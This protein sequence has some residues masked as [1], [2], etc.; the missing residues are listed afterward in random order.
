MKHI[1]VL[2][3]T[4][5]A[6]TGCQSLPSV[7][8]NND[9]HYE[10]TYETEDFSFTS[11][12][13]TLT[14]S[15][16][17]NISSYF[18]KYASHMS[19][20]K[21]YTFLYKGKLKNRDFKLN[22]TYDSSK[23]ENPYLIASTWNVNDSEDRPYHSY[24]FSTYTDLTSDFTKLDFK[25]YY[26]YVYLEN[27]KDQEATC[28][29]QYKDIAFKTAPMI[30]STTFSILSKDEKISKSDNEIGASGFECVRALSAYINSLL[31]AVGNY[32]I[33]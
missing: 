10:D 7:G 17:E 18:L 14:D 32:T 21:D 27:A 20:D 26:S 9:I 16:K 11:N 5:I 8:E 25:V 24:Y 29:I 28:T 19:K 1:K 23:T 15:K 30:E 31:K 13:N 2:L 22:V 12:E 4:A 6:L 3:L 33:W